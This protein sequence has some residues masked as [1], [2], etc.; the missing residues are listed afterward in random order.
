M[1]LVSILC[2]YIHFKSHSSA[3]A[4][5]YSC[6]ICFH[7]FYENNYY[8]VVIALLC[9]SVLQ[10]ELTP[11]FILSQNASIPRSKT[12]SKNTAPTKMVNAYVDVRLKNILCKLLP[13]PISKDF[14]ISGRQDVTST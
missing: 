13:S 14:S 1:T 6:F 8:C 3:S 7:N 5:S 4:T 12:L 11:L 10:I 9:R 2:T